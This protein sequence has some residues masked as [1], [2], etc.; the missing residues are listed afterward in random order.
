[1]MLG[2]DF[3]SDN[4]CCSTVSDNYKTNDTYSVGFYLH[5]DNQNINMIACKSSSHYRNIK[6]VDGRIYAGGQDYRR[7]YLGNIDG[8]GRG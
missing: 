3:G 1:M 8:T 4:V 5:G 2:I 6:V 7:Q